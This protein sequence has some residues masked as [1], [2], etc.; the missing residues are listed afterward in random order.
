[1]VDAD[2]KGRCYAEFRHVRKKPERQVVGT[3][4]KSGTKN[5]WRSNSSGKYRNTEQSE[6]RLVRKHRSLVRKTPKHRRAGTSDPFR[7][8]GSST[9]A[10]D[11]REPRHPEE[12]ESE[13]DTKSETGSVGEPKTGSRNRKKLRQT[14]VRHGARRN[15]SRRAEEPEEPQVELE[16]E[17]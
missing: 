7:N 4:E 12:G 16:G 14:Q 15:R 10:E 17:C 3:P 6:Y 13:A 1:M 11:I 9:R 8:T 2:Q 5:S